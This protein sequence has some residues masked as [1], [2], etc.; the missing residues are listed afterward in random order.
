MLGTAVIYYGTEQGFSGHGGDNQ[1]REAMFDKNVPGRN[2]L[3]RD[4]RIYREIAR[5]ADVL[6]E[7]EPLRFG[8]MYYRHISGDGE[9]FGFPYGATYT[10]AFSR[11]LYGQEILVAY[12]VSSQPRNDHV[13]VDATLHADGSSMRFLYGGAG[14]TQVSTASD[15]SRSVQLNLAPHGFAILR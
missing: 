7:T 5:I 10:L 9:H 11:V 14:T 3:N 2:L 1:M 4:C 8:R 12:N 6:R 15:G 13:I